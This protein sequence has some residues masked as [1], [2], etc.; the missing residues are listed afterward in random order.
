MHIISHR[1]QLRQNFIRQRQALPL[2]EQYQS[3]M[4]ITQHIAENS[5]FK[6]SNHIAFYQAVR[7]EIDVLPLLQL[8]CTQNKKCY[9]PVL[10]PKQN[11]QLC[12]IQYQP[13]DTLIPNRYKILEPVFQ[14][15]KIISPEELD[16]VLVPLVA[17]DKQGH[18]IGSGAGYYDRTFAFLLQQKKP[19]K[20]YLLGV[21]YDWQCVDKVSSEAWDVPVDSVVTDKGISL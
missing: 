15:D 11:N 10:D 7:G 21:C 20:P 3:A 14:M 5:I 19:A 16:L 12:F 6:K 13:G 1:Q 4:Q 18:R 8:A 17:V 2:S 9:L